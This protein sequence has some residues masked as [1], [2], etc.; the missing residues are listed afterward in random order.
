MCN[1]FNPSHSLIKYTYVTFIFQFHTAS[2]RYIGKISK[3]API[4][5]Q[6]HT[7]QLAIYGPKLKF[8]FPPSFHSNLLL[9][10]Y[11]ALTIGY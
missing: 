9:I 4:F 6:N 5:G 1:M 10:T 2:G 11:L 3:S 8:Q 7:F